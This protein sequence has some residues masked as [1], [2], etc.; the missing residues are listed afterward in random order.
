[1]ECSNITDNTP[2]KKVQTV[3]KGFFN[4][5]FF[6]LLNKR[7]S[8]LNEADGQSIAEVISLRS[9]SSELSSF[10]RWHQ[11]QVGEILEGKTT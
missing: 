4:S 6:N 9:Q 8:F 1:M 10:N 3:S 5:T 7:R 2:R 11:L